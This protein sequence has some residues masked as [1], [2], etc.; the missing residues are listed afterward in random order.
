MNSYIEGFSL[1]VISA[2]HTAVHIYIISC[3]KKPDQQH[4]V[5]LI[6]LYYANVLDICMCFIGFVGQF[7]PLKKL[8]LEYIAVALV[9]TLTGY[10]LLLLRYIALLFSPVDCWLLLAKPFY[11]SSSLFIRK[12]SIWLDLARF[13]DCMR[14]SPDGYIC[15]DRLRNTML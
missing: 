8:T 13:G 7:C 10:S 14:G 6:T 1:D 5:F 2:L 15:G 11:Y 9:S 3:L 12:Y 4:N